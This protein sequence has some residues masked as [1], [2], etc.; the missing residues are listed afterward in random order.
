MQQLREIITDTLLFTYYYLEL[1][2]SKIPVLLP[3]HPA[4]CIYFYPLPPPHFPSTA[5]AQNGSDTISGTFWTLEQS[6]RRRN[7]SR[8]PPTMNR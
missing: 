6:D 8:D 5:N 1:E 2:N 7:S 4:L 3:R